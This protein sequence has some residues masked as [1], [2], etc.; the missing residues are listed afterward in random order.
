MIN[1]DIIIIITFL[2]ANLI[3]G[4]FSG[5]VKT[6]KEYA[7]GKQDFS[8]SDV[9][10]TIVATWVGGG[11][12]SN[13]LQKTYTDGFKF[14]VADIAN[15]F[16]FIFCYILVPRMGEFLGTTSIAAAM[17]NIYGKYV[18]LVTAV[19]GLVVS[20]GFV[21]IQLKVFGGL[22]GHFF[23]VSVI[24]A[25]LVSGLVIVSYSCFGGIRAVTFTDILQFFT[26]CAFIPILG[27]SIWKHCSTDIIDIITN[28]PLLNQKDIFNNT[29]E[30]LIF[31]TLSLYF[32][33]PSFYPAYFQ[34]FAI[35]KNIFQLRK[36]FLIATLIL[37][38]MKVFIALI[39][40]FLYSINPTLQPNLILGYIIDNYS[41]P[42]LKGIIV[43]GLA[44]LIMSTADSHINAASILVASDIID[45]NNS[46]NLFRC[47]L[48]SIIIGMLGIVLAISQD[49]ILDIMLMSAS[50][51][52]PIVTV[53][54][55]FTIIGFRSSGKS[56]LIGMISGFITVIIWR[57]FFMNTGVDSVIPGIIAN[58]L[59]LFG[60][61]YC[62]KQKGGW[63]I[64][65]DSYTLKAIQYEKK[66]KIIHI[67][68]SFTRFDLIKFLEK[69]TPKNNITFSFFGIF[70]FF[71]TI[72]SIYTMKIS[73]LALEE[74]LLTCIFQIMLIIT[75]LFICYPIW[76]KKLNKKLKQIFWII[77]V[78]FLL[79]LCNSF[80]VIINNF[81]TS[82]LI[83]FALNIVVLA[84]LMR[85]KVASIITIIGIFCSIQLYKYFISPT[86]QIKITVSYF[87]ITYIF[88]LISTI[89]VAFIVPSEKEKELIEF[90]L[91]QLRYQNEKRKKAF[92]KALQY[93]TE[94]FN[95]IDQ[96]C[97]SLFQD[98]N[99]K[100][101]LLN[102][103]IQ[104]CKEPEQILRKSQKL[105]NIVLK[106]NEGGKYFHKVISQLQHDLKINLKEVNLQYFLQKIVEQQKPLLFNTKVLFQFN[107]VKS[108]Y[109]DVVL[110]TQI[111]EFF[112]QT[113][114]EH[115][116]QDVI[117]IKVEDTEIQYDLSFTE[118]M[119][120]SRNAIKITVIFENVKIEPQIISILLL[121]LNDV[122]S[123]YYRITFAHFGKCDLQITEKKELCYSLTIPRELNKIRPTKLDLPN[124]DLEKMISMYSALEEKSKLIK[125]SIAKKLL[126]QG[127]DNYIIAKST[128]LSIEEI[129]SCQN[130]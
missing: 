84:M 48:A 114:I 94:F 64:I 26:F 113:G 63:G 74:R 11:M 107:E 89:I 106:I 1:L 128:G 130:V 71:S 108:I 124:N 119:K 110:I 83:I 8:T 24:Y 87:Y 52:M 33:L 97:I 37:L 41:Y 32:A 7:V 80:F 36:A 123:D 76:P 86:L 98:L 127:I 104:Q 2:L 66:R 92:L 44:A 96:D 46:N 121:K 53:P 65:K 34:R 126:E 60:S 69:N 28:S 109:L 43:S 125:I 91:D 12:F 5:K 4:I 25:I 75:T 99:Q 51:Y 50:F 9:V 58:L 103:D 88:L 35:A 55:I 57:M 40:T 56:V 72:A 67:W 93:K 105:S 129:I 73:V 23:D 100:I 68:H 49:N 81:A 102:E 62:L 27:F 21:G 118:K 59:F 117:V 61:H 22:I 120:A 3:I 85:W 20:V 77:G 112:I 10:A 13:V 30:F 101:Q 38:L 16:S 17:G 111:I 70:S 6:I 31:I 82:Q 14:F 95:K 116:V 122:N 45:T 47:R 78:F 15:C 39:S 90:F 18:K 42:G 79:A 115:T 29:Q 54:F 19:A